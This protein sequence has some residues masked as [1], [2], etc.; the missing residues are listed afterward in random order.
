MEDRKKNVKECEH[1]FDE[2]QCTKLTKK[3]DFP[4][5]IGPKREVYTAAQHN[6]N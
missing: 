2:I 4:I 5:K 6:K 3:Y 1:A